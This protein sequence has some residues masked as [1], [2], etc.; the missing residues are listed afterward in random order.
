MKKTYSIMLDKKD[1]KKAKNFLR[2]MEAYFEPSER[3]EFIM[4]SVDLDDEEL[5]CVNSFLDTL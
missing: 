2:S 3:G 1:A 5:E 4:I